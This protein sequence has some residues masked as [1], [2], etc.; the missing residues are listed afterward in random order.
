M[1][2]TVLVTLAIDTAIVGHS[3]A[4]GLSRAGRLRTV[5]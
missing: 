2:E 1:K 5:V 4:L 3:R